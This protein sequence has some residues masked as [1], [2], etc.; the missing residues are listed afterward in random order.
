MVGHDWGALITV[1]AAS[2]RP[3]L[4]N[5]WCASNALPH[6]DYQWHRM[7]KLWQTPVIG[8]LVMMF[9]NR[10]KLADALN[11]AGMPAEMAAKEASHWNRTMRSS[12]LKL[13]RSARHAGDEW[14]DELENL[15]KQGLVFWGEDDPFVPLWVAEKFCDHTGADLIRQ[16]KT[17]HWSVVE[18]AEELAQAL[19]THWA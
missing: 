4:I 14:W 3:D 6:P 17:G 13:Y 16:P 5:S 8:E 19:Q 15:P 11:E 9:S 7:A 18:R 10:K 2:R 1:R 12:I